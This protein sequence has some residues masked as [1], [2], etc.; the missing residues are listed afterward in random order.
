MSLSDWLMLGILIS[1]LF[2]GWRIIATIHW[3]RRSL[4]TFSQ[5]YTSS[6]VDVDGSPM[7]SPISAARSLTYIANHIHESEHAKKAAQFESEELRG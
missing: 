7:F 3:L 2:T 6:V 1:I 4:E 5:T